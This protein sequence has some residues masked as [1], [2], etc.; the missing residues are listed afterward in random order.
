MNNTWNYKEDLLDSEAFEK[1][2]KQYVIKI[3]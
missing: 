1:I 3:P 2:E